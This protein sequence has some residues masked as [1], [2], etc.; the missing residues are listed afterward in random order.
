MDS[1]ESI[2][3]FQGLPTELWESILWQVDPRT[4]LASATRVC[5]AWATLIQNSTALQ[6]L[7]FF[8]PDTRVPSDEK[9]HCSLLVDAFPSVLFKHAKR[10]D[11]YNFTIA[12]WDFIKHPEKQLA[13]LRPEASWRRMLVQQPPIYRIAIWNESFATIPFSQYYEMP[14]FWIDG[15]MN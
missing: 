15:A 14:E 2:N 1:S 4:L 6:Q 7:L 12:T 10:G 5:H 3:G 11:D 9:T 13:Y 8:A